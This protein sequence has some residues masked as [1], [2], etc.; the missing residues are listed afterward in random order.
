MPPRT[1]TFRLRAPD[2]GF[3]VKLAGGLAEPVPPGRRSQRRLHAD[4]RHGALPDRASRAARDPLRPQP[5]LPRVVAR[6]AARRQP[7]RDRDAVRPTPRPGGAGDRAGASRLDR[8]QRPA[9]PAARGRQRFPSQVHTTPRPTSTSSRSTRRSRRSTTSACGGRS[10]S[11]ST[12][13]IARIYGGP[14]AAARCQ[15]L[16]PGISATGPT[17][18]TRASPGRRGWRGPDLAR[19]APA[20]GRSGTR[21][22]RVNVWGWTDDPDDQP[23]GVPLRRRGAA[24]LGYRCGR[25]V[26]DRLRHA[27][28]GLPTPI[29]LI[30][31]GGR[32]PP[33]TS[34]RRGSAATGRQ[35]RL[36]L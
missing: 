5:V 14:A 36:V 24:P 22:A 12:G 17:A 20:R 28:P 7:R 18:R 13:R 1:V 2:P 4:P 25:I 26:R 6:R 21:G 35:R 32:T 27:P 29:Q 30:P 3:L 9:R 10:T 23:R 31:A 8:R 11:R 15:A 16:P 19:G 33:T 34:S